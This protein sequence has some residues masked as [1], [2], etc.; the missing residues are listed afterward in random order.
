MTCLQVH[1]SYYGHCFLQ[2]VFSH[3]LF[4]HV[5]ALIFCDGDGASYGAL[6]T[7]QT[8][9]VALSPPEP[10]QILLK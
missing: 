8:A 5:G 4:Y 2:F 1:H 10:A 9:K 6:K 3:F 7:V